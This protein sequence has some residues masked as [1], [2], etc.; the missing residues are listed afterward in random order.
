MMAPRRPA[1]TPAGVSLPPARGPPGPARSA[2]PARCAATSL[3][4][5]SAMIKLTAVTHWGIPGN[6]LDAAG[7]VYTGIIGFPAPGPPSNG[8]KSCMGGLGQ[9]VVLFHR[10][11]GLGR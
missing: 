4:R 3:P 1:V 5:S 8:P 7:Q 9:G 10:Q 2:T 6:D 11:G